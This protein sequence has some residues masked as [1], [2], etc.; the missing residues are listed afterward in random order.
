MDEAARILSIRDLRV[1]FRSGAQSAA[2]VDGVSYDVFAG[3]TLGVVGNRAAGR[4]SPRSPSCVSSP[5]RR[6]RSIP[7][8][9]S[10]TGATFWV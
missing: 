2:A 7:A 6:G 10:S 3:E 4:A 9:S 8:P 1:S 5:R